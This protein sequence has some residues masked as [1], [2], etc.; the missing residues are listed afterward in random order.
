MRINIHYKIYSRKIYFRIENLSFADE[1]NEELLVKSEN[2]LET[3]EYKFDSKK[4]IIQFKINSFDRNFFFK[5]SSLFQN[6][7]KGFINSSTRKREF[8]AKIWTWEF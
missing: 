8:R 4:V 7:K 5:Y 2:D 1:N 3:K 6:N